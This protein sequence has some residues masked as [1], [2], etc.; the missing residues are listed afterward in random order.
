MSSDDVPNNQVF[1]VTIEFRNGRTAPQIQNLMSALKQ[2]AQ[3][4]EEPGTGAKPN[5]IVKREITN[6]TEPTPP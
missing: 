3:L 5:V 4:Q 6:A 1:R 2:A